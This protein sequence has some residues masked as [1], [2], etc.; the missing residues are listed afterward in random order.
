[1]TLKREATRPKQ[2][3]N[4][5]R[6]A[7]NQTI[8]ELISK[9]ELKPMADQTSFHPNAMAPILRLVD[10][11]RG[12]RPFQ[13][14]NMLSAVERKT[15]PTGSKGGQKQVGLPSLKAVHSKLPLLRFLPTCQ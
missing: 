5:F 8:H 11:P 14:D 1:L 3:L 7:S 12:P 4:A 6:F 9:T 10:V 13:E 15:K 2:Q